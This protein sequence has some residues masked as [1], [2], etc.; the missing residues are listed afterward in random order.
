MAT[1]YTDLPAAAALDGSE[2]LAV[3][4]GGDSVQATTQDIANLGGAVGT[5][6]GIT[7]TLTDQ[8]DLVTY[9]GGI[10]DAKVIDSI[11]DSDTTHAPSRNAV[12]DALALKENL[13][14]TFDR[15]TTDYSLV[16]ADASKGI[17]MNVAIANTV[18][19]P[20][21]A[22][23]AFPIN[24]IIPIA[25]YGAGLT[26][27]VATGGVTIRNTAGSLAGQGQYNVMFLKKIATD[28]WYLWNGAPSS[29][30]VTNVATSAPI[31]GGPITS[32]GTIGITQSNTTTDGY[33]SSTDWN[34]FNNKQSTGLSWLLASGGAMT[35]NN[36]I[37]GAFKIT[38][39]NTQSANNAVTH[40]FTPGLTATANADVLTAFNINP[41]FTLGAFTPTVPQILRLQSAG[42]TRFAF[43]SGG[44]LYMGT[45][46]SGTGRLEIKQLG[47]NNTDGIKLVNSANSSEGNIYY[48]SGSNFV[49]DVNS[50]TNIY[51][52]AAGTT[53]TG[54]ATFTGGRIVSYTTQNNGN[55][56][57]H[58]IGSTQAYTAASPGPFV[59]IIATFTSPGAQTL[60]FVGA[61][62]NITETGAVTARYNIFSAKPVLAMSGSITAM[63]IVGFNYEPTRTGVL[64]TL[65]YPFY[66][67]SSVGRSAFGVTTPTA[68]LHIGAGATGLAPLKLTSGT[69]LTTAEAGAFEYNGTNLFFTRAGTTREGV[70]TQSAVTT[71]VIVSDTSVTINIGGTTYKLLARA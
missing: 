16:L 57:R 49:I 18:T 41:T 37:S 68:R 45:G 6:G 53:N 31:T 19:V 70:L 10:A 50:S 11:A 9:V 7:G 34:T 51:V 38:W 17:E 71:E 63:T 59:D 8:T 23:E 48:S 27:V 1:K 20:L 69:N 67:P 33:I 25:Q 46:T 40:D 15:K 28:E 62:P 54:S 42:T 60:D 30:T 26:T 66:D 39:T 4:Q 12:F 52:G 65:E 44:S 2:I 22:T 32:T 21:N 24:T 29:G 13:Y 35:A 14:R 64:N 5:W 47:Q 58:R 3:V 56:G 36:T 61:L 55:S 43:S